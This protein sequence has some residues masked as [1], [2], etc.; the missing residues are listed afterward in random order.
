MATNHS[1]SNPF[2]IM[3]YM[4]PTYFCDRSDETKELR[5]ALN[6]RRNVTLIS[7]RRMGKTGLIRHFFQHLSAND[8]NCFY[9]DIYDTKNLYDFTKVFAESV[10]TKRITPFSD[11]VWKEISQ[12]F[13]GL[14][15]VISMDPITGM[16]Q[17]TVDIHPQR[18]EW[19]LQQI[20]TYLEQSKLP[21][22]VAFDEF[23]E[24]AKY[25]EGKAEATL[26]SSIQH[27]NNVQFVFAGSR[28]HIMTE[29]FSSPARPFFQSTQMMSIDAIDE[30]AYYEFAAGHF[31]AHKQS[32]DTSTF[33]ELYALVKGHTWY[34][35]ALLNRLYQSG[36]RE[37]GYNDVL[38]VLYQWLQ[39]NTPTYQTYCRLITNRQLEVMRAIAGEGEVR[40]TGSN[41]FLRNHLLGAYSTVRSAITALDEKELLYCDDRGYYSVYD[42]FFGIWLKNNK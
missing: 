11:R 8:V 41:A 39:E 2:S 37:I 40:E 1:V 3:S 23:Q 4:G 38:S 20:F 5:D 26:R 33:H 16:P 19:T 32:I 14:R 18:E 6:N 34:V 12:F 22:Y 13:G 31:A 42:R 15:P 9:I 35:Q 17:C 7:P 21:C 28:K 36:V 25:V 27:L 24:V 10:L 29:M 30:S